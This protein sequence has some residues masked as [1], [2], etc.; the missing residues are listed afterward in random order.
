MFTECCF[1]PKKSQVKY[2][3]VDMPKEDA[4]TTQV[5]IEEITEKDNGKMRI[6]GIYNGK[7]LYVQY[8]SGV[9]YPK[10]SGDKIN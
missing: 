6:K 5:S 2:T 4:E 10:H 1:K 7:W 8:P 3:D 9:Q